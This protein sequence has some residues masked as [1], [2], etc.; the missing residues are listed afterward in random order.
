MEELMTGDWRAALRD[1]AII[2]L[3]GLPLGACLVFALYVILP[4][5]SFA[6]LVTVPLLRMALLTPALIGALWETF[7][8]NYRN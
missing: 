6:L 3:V 4:Q 1:A 2:V 7:A 5:G 8:P